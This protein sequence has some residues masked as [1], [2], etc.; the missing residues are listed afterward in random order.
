MF[1]ATAP[2]VFGWFCSCQ[3]SARKSGLPS[4]QNRTI[5]G[6]SGRAASGVQTAVPVGMLEGAASRITNRLVRAGRPT[7]KVRTGYFCGTAVPAGS[8]S[9]LP[10]D[11]G[12]NRVR[13]SRS[14]VASEKVCAQKGWPSGP[15]AFLSTQHQAEKRFAALTVWAK[16][17]AK[18]PTG[19]EGEPFCW[20][21]RG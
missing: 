11:N 12:S 5:H 13:F 15:D 8:D 19:S 7:L 10:T 14:S 20:P 18:W 16:H 4:S 2:T 17:W 9:R 3:H 6:S 1:L 21:E